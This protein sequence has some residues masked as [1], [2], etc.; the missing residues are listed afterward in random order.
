MISHLSRDPGHVRSFPHE[1]LRIV[2]ENG[3]KHEFLFW[4]KVGADT[5]SLGRLL[6]PQHD[7]FSISE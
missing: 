1:H 3:D 7:V 6:G 2:P 4:V 5:N